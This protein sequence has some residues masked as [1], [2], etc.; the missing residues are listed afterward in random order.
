MHI[1]EAIIGLEKKVKS[2]TILVGALILLVFVPI[3]LGGMSF[4]SSSNTILEGEGLILRSADGQVRAE[5]LMEENGDPKLTLYDAKG[6][7]GFAVNIISGHRNRL[8]L[9]NENGGTAIRLSGTTDEPSVYVYHGTDPD[10]SK[11]S[12]FAHIGV[13]AN[14]SPILYMWNDTGETS[15][16]LLVGGNGP[17]LTL[18]D[19]EGNALAK[20]PPN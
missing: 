13:S 17:E 12:P 4:T 14:G 6:R 16:R 5:I 15:A 3:L 11:P 19:I 8:T 9:S 1:N 7:I 2:L 10:Q 18:T 20:L